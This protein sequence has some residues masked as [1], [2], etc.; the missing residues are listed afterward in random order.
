MQEST[1]ED[2]VEEQKSLASIELL[3]SLSHSK[4]IQ[5]IKVVDMLLQSFMLRETNVKDICVDLFN[6]GK[7]ENTWGNAP[8]K[9][10]DE[11]LITL[12]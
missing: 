4:A 10:R 1:I 11:C 5:F 2:L 6:E 8:R 12:K 3:S 9:P 7:I